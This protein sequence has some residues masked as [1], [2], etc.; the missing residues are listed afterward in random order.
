MRIMDVMSTE[1]VTVA[2]DSTLKQIATV[3][4]SHGISGAPVVDSK[5]QVLGIVSETDLVVE[6]SGSDRVARRASEVMTAPAITIDIGRRVYEAARL[7]SEHRINRL[8]VLNDGTL[9][10]IVSRADIVRAFARADD[11][12]RQEIVDDV[13]AQVL[14]IQP[15]RVWV[16]VAEGE[17][18]L[19]GGLDSERDAALLV[20]F[21]ERVPGVVSVNSTLIWP[22][23][24]Q[25]HQPDR[26]P[27]G[28]SRSS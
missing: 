11:Q 12:I 22:N 28:A 15:D 1:V 19:G 13:V 5:G 4:A 24:D 23:V 16:A 18:T 21:A 20:R 2:P 26:P 6:E 3:L 17:V 8:P 7:M 9:A 27:V 25:T 10:G 14:Q